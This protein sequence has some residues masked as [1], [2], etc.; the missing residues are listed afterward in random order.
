MA[1]LLFGAG[2]QLWPSIP[3]SGFGQLPS[4][5]ASR[6][7]MLFQ[8]TAADAGA[9]PMNTGIASPFDFAAGITP[10]ALLATV[11]LRRGQPTGPA[12]DQDVED[13]IYDALELLPGANDIE[14]RCDGGRVT[15]S[16]S[17]PHKRV[18]RDAGEIV[19]AIPSINDV[20]NNITIATRR[21]SRTQARE[22]EAGSSAPARKTA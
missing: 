5:P 11:A 12:N 18:K 9:T 10:Q 13:F 8:G 14:V 7:A 22:T 17:T 20:Q 1:E 6:A 15:L 3:T 19:W 16:G 4:F 2:P 21:R